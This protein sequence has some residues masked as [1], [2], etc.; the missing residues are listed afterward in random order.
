[1]YADGL[2]VPEGYFSLGI[3]NDIFLPYDV[4]TAN[5]RRKLI[6]TQRGEIELAASQL[7]SEVLRYLN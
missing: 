5:N 1:M 2:K 6:G 4:I 7:P 3:D